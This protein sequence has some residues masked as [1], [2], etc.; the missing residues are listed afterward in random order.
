[1]ECTIE[2]SPHVVSRS[3]RRFLRLVCHAIS[4]LRKRPSNR[5][6]FPSVTTCV[7]VCF[8]PPLRLFRL[9]H[10]VPP[11]NFLF[12]FHHILCR[13]LRNIFTFPSLILSH[14]FSLST[15]SPFSLSIRSFFPYFLFPS[16]RSK[17]VR[18]YV[19]SIH[20]N[21][22]SSRVPRTWN[23]KAEKKGNFIVLE[24]GGINGSRFPLQ[25]YRLQFGHER[26]SLP[27]KGWRIFRVPLYRLPVDGSASFL[28][29]LVS[30]RHF[31]PRF[32]LIFDTAIEIFP[33]HFDTRIEGN[34]L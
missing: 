29:P 6:A 21:R 9:F 13:T 18:I 23:W 22:G 25:T 26:S 24:N 7:Y 27:Q 33:R 20:S 4:R 1:M 2:L 10:P 16:L 14:D 5:S 31:L 3:K 12:S 30:L 15:I 34:S 11:F 17:L 8:H 28:F 32:F 19:S